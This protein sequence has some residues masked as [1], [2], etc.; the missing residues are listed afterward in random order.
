MP[1]PLPPILP[2][3]PEV[4]IET[5]ARR[6]PD[7]DLADAFNAGVSFR[8]DM[9]LPIAGWPRCPDENTYNRGKIDPENGDTPVFLPWTIY[10]PVKC[11]GGLVNP[12]ELFESGRQS[13][14]AKRPYAI[15]REV[16]TGEISGSVS[17]QSAAVDVSASS[18]TSA[19]IA[20]S[21]LIGNYRDATLGSQAWLH[22]PDGLLHQ[23]D[24][25]VE[26]KGDRLLT[27][28]GDVV[29]P[30]PG[31]PSNDGNWGPEGAATGA[32]DAWMYVTGP[33]ELAVGHVYELGSGTTPTGSFARM[34]RH[35]LYVEQ[36]AIFRFPP[37]AV[38][39]VK[40]NKGL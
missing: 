24:D 20:A 33:V 32:D 8:D 5:S 7:R 21:T 3:A 22:V 31:Y 18:P 16:W 35:V 27:K 37:C 39:A 14:A 6:F 1:Q 28:T 30:G 13:L 17:L 26:R 11:D 15:A 25:F 19:K 4:S 38:F 12:D 36:D 29:V 34:N 2:S 23:L 40:V 9:C 10:A